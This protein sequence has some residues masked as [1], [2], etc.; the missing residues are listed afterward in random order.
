M[1][2]DTDWSRAHVTP[3]MAFDLESV[4]MPG[5]A[6]YLTDPIEAPSNWKDQEK[7]AKYIEEAKQK[8]IAKAGLDLDLCEIVA[9]ATQFP[10]EQYCQMRESWS[11]SWSE[12]DMLDGFWRFVR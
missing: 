7:I 4:P 12:G 1:G 11:G 8:Q 6:D 3:W 10:T 9:I 2:Y 5:C